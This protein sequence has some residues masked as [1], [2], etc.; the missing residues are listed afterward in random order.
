M[1]ADRQFTAIIEREG[2]GFYALCP[3]L[4]IAS[5]VDTVEEARRTIREL[6]RRSVRGH[7]RAGRRVGV[8]DAVGRT[9]FGRWLR[10]GK[11]IE[12]TVDR[13]IALQARLA[14]VVGETRLPRRL[15]PRNSAPAQLARSAEHIGTRRGSTPEAGPK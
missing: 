3:E 8:T 11:A 2:D 5:E 9:R 10:A 1:S 4:D 13:N 6:T 15:E 14:R 7:T 12:G